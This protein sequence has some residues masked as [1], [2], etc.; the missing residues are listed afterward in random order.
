MR[1]VDS[2]TVTVYRYDKILSKKV[3]IPLYETFGHV[4]LIKQKES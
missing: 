4:Q 3:G 2:M 1:Q